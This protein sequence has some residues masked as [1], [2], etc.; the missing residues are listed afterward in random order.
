MKQCELTPCVMCGQGVGHCGPMF[1][2]VS[3]K[4][5]VINLD[6]VKR[7]VGLEMMMGGSALLANVLGRNEDM[8]TLLHEGHGLV[9]MDCGIR[10]PI[11]ILFEAASAEES[12]GTDHV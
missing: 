3:F 12:E 4:Q 6:A 2:E 11:A 9:C 5:L 7:Q 8:A 1:Y 10:T